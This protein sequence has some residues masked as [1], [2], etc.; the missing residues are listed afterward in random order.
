MNAVTPGRIAWAAAVL[1]LLLAIGFLG[2]RIFTRERQGAAGTEALGEEPEG[3]EFRTVTLYFGDPD[4]VGLSAE[5]RDVLARSDLAGNLT[6]ALEDLAAGPLT[7]LVPTLPPGTRVR[8]VY[9]DGSGTVYVDFSG[10]LLA[11]PAGGLSRELLAVCSIARTL[12][13]NFSGLSRFQILVEGRAV[14]TLGGHLDTGRPLRLSEW[15]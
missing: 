10:E 4:S 9:L 14:P 2:N 8:H 6:G 13:A 1:A 3:I 12:S 5:R 7:R 11:G 15:N